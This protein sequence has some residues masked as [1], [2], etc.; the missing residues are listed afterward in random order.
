[1]DKP[2]GDITRE[3]KLVQIKVVECDVV[4]S[5]FH[6]VGKIVGHG[7]RSSRYE[8]SLDVRATSEGWGGI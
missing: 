6:E 2:D 5:W 4:V 8:V 7:C 3:G 1:M